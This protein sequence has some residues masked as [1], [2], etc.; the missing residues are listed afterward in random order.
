MNKKQLVPD[1]ST[2]CLHLFYCDS[3]R[4]TYRT[5]QIVEQE[6]GDTFALLIAENGDD[7]TKKEKKN[8]IR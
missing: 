4:L 5:G 7:A 8:D 2:I 1:A 6:P 3:A